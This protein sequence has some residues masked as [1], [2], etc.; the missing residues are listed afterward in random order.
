M[1]RPQLAKESKRSKKLV[2]R[3]TESELKKLLELAAICGKS[4]SEL[5]REKLF[6]GR[7]P[8]SKTA[9]L[10]LQTYTE[11]KKIGVNINQLAWKVNSGFLPLNLLALLSKLSEQQELIILKLT[12]D[13]H[14]EN[15]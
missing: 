14:S 6:T 9:K 10:D 3:L 4:S 13:S 12:Y 1:G 15:R 5:I 8:Q 2:F 7:F 11:L